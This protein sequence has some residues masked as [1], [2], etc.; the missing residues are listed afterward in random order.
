MFFYCDPRSHHHRIIDHCWFGA[1]SLASAR[2]TPTAFKGRSLAAVIIK[3]AAGVSRI[4]I[5]RVR[6][7][8]L[9]SADVQFKMVLVQI[10]CL[11]R[12]LN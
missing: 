7:G 8:T 10:D 1:G 11:A 12:D 5:A 4:S 6:P 2:K 3:G 9:T